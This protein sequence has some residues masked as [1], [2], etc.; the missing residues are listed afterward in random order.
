MGQRGRDINLPLESAQDRLAAQ[1]TG[2]RDINLPIETEYDRIAARAIEFDRIAQAARQTAAPKPPPKP[3]QRGLL[4]D[5]GLGAAKGTGNTM[6][7]VARDAGRSPMNPMNMLPDAVNPLAQLPDV[8]RMGVQPGY[9]PPAIEQEARAKLTPENLTQRLGSLVPDVALGAVT[10]GPTVARGVRAGAR[11]LEKNAVPGLTDDAADL[12]L[13]NMSG[14]VA[15]RNAAAATRAAQPTTLPSS[16]VSTPNATV[17]NAATSMTNAV[18]NRQPFSFNDLVAP[19]GL[20]YLL[21]PKTGYAAL[22]L[23]LLNRPGVKSGIA[24][25]AYTGSPVL[26]AAGA[27]VGINAAQRLSEEEMR[28][29]AI[30]RQLGAGGRDQR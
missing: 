5:F 24:Q 13:K 4:A 10:G 21:G 25:G 7:D 22:A 17:Q 6:L 9:L 2:G 20:S 27:G 29:E 19:A 16:A 23:R 14:R 30:L 3:P 12:L 1:G 15:P 26:G 11:A 28:R 8:V 18:A